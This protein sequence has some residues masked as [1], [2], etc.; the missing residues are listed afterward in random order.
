MADWESVREEEIHLRDYW[1]VIRKRGN[2]VVM[3]FAVVVAVA[4]VGTLTATPVY[5]ASTRVLIDRENQYI[6]NLNQGY[7]DFY[8]EDYYHTQYELI[9]STAVAYRVVKNLN[10]EENPGFNPSAKRPGREG[11]GL[12][13]VLSGIF[14][15]GK[16][17]AQPPAEDQ[18]LALAR[19]IQG[20]LR[21]EPV[22]NSRIVNISY[23]YRDPR[24]AAA[25]ANGVAT[26][27]VE[28]VLEIKMGT[29]KQ[30]VEWM[31]KKIDEQ[32]KALEESQRAL[33]EYMKDKDVVELENMKEA[34]TPQKVQNLGA[35]L[36][37]AEAKRKET[38]ASY[39]QA[40]GFTNNLTGALTV[41]AIAGDPVMQS[42]R[43]EEIKIEKDIMEMSKK[44]GD[45]HPLMIRL[46]EDLRA[47]REKM[48]SEA[49]RIITSMKND[50][51][52]AKAREAGLRNSLAQGKGEAMALSEK[53][54]QYG[55]LKREVESNQQMYD[56]LLKRIKETSLIEE[57]KSFNIY[58]VDKAEV[59][60]G[61]VR[62]RKFLNVLMSV[63]VGLFG[64]VGVAFFLEYID[65]TFKKPEDVEEKLS[66]PVL[67]VIPFIKQ[68][69]I[70]DGRFEL[71]S[72]ADQKSSISEAYRALRTSLLLSAVEPI[73]S[74]AV[75]SCI[76][77]EGKTT[78]A[79]NLATTLAQ[80]EKMVLLVDADLRKP[81]VHSVLGLDNSVG[82]SNFLARQVVQGIIKDSAVPNLSVITSGPLPPN[83]SEL[84]GSQRMKEFLDIVTEKFDV[85]LFD[86][87]PLI[88]VTD[89]TILTDA[90][91]GAVLVIK[92]G[93]TTFDVAGRGVKLLKDVNAKILGIVLNSVD[94]KKEGYRYLY[95]YY[96]QYG[97]ERKKTM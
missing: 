88:T 69:D 6:Q 47:L 92:S 2:S 9:K 8:S 68:S 94:A 85:I 70:Q 24:M 58:I 50:Y 87:A 71:V 73:K 66:L 61:P 17:P 31:S 51:E 12:F 81:K 44:Y 90:V 10:L 20:G 33:Q 26:A 45:K 36:V 67:G 80:M 60:K 35:Q 1:K 75:T 3:F 63:I 11:R 27:Y 74:F 59:P 52:L 30:A 54:I 56:A 32:K 16:T 84:L 65:N 15:T 62:P 22:K 72:H 43:T 77:D 89:T 46:R 64:G 34:L 42:L 38:E 96:Y 55:V 95:P 13:G 25:I 19:K 41:P 7:V 39:S 93:T 78:T 4:T 48:A 76:E 29:A 86:T 40:K 28:Q 97:A 57:V 21:V 5:R 23:E 37:M 49:K 82:L 18:A 14:K 91:D 79:I 53:S 83:P